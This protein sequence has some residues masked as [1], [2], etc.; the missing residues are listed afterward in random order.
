MDLNQFSPKYV[1]YEIGTNDANQAEW[2]INTQSVINAIVARGA[3]PILCTQVPRPAK[4]A[5]ITA[6][7]SDIRSRFFGD[8]D[9]IDLALAVSLNNAGVEYDPVYYQ[10][11]KVHLTVEGEEKLF[12]QVLADAPF[13][14]D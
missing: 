4:Q 8:Y 7:N 5:Q 12:S 9:Y 13:L 11:D 10:Q 1:I 3:T 14:L 6:Q 2:R